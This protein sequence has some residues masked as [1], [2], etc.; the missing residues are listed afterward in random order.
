[1][2]KTTHKPDLHSKAELLKAL[3]HPERLAILHLLCKA[4]KGRLTVKAIY[5]S[6]EAQQ[7]A[8]SRHLGILKN[9]GVVHRM[10]EGQKT[11]YGLRTRKKKI[12][13]LLERFY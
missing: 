4:P 10:Q 9:S 6:L 3:A 7:A 1:M 13:L 11:F 8:I 2:G 12:E 5:E